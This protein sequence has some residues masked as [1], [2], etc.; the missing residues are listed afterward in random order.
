MFENKTKEDKLI[1]AKEVS[2]LTTLSR[3]TIRKLSRKGAFPRK[4]SLARNKVAWSAIA[5]QSWIDH[6]VKGR[7]WQVDSA[8]ASHGLDRDIESGR[9]DETKGGWE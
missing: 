8:P 3:T 5:V 6:K 9:Y 4:I 2:A 7:D 1:T